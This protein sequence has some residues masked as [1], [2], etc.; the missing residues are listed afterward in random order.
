MDDCSSK[1]RKKQFSFRKIPLD[2]IEIIK[3]STLSNEE[4]SKK[5][6]VTPTRIKQIKQNK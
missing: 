1:G 3:N 2:Q 5:Y 4:L 6:N